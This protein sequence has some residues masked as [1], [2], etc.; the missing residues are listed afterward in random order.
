MTTPRSFGVFAT[1]FAVV[2]AL[3]Y[4]IAV[5]NN[6]ALF[7]YH[8]AIGQFGGG[9]QPAREGPAMYWFGWLATSGLA[10]SVA[11]VLASFLPESLTRKLWSGWTWVVAAGVMVAFCYFLRNFF[12][13]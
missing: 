6:Y 7:T 5:E 1:A 13:R 8:P 12:L 9:V 10:A 3:A 2:F 11:G 4:V